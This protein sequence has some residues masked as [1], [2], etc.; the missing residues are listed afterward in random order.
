MKQVEKK[1]TSIM[2]SIVKTW[3]S[4][5]IYICE[6]NP[7]SLQSKSETRGLFS[8]DFFKTQVASD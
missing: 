3:C 8:M 2:K 7:K 5:Q 1:T 6:E 4:T